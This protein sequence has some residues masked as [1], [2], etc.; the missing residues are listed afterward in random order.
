MTLN[1]RSRI[2]EI[3]DEFIRLV[4][5]KGAIDSDRVI[6]DFDNTTLGDL[7]KCVYPQYEGIFREYIEDY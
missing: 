5:K 2:R 3:Q 6:D 7:R 4:E 1:K